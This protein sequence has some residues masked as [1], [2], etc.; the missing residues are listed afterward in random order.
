ML[1]SHLAAARRNTTSADRRQVVAPSARLAYAVTSAAV[2]QIGVPVITT[3]AAFPRWLIP[4][5]VGC[6]Y[7]IGRHRVTLDFITTMLGIFTSATYV[8]GFLKRE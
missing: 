5:P 8:Y 7:T 1:T 6:R 2:V 4:S 3:E